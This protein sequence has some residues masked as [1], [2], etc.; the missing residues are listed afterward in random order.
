MIRRPPR[1]TLFPYTTLF[2]SL[3]HLGDPLAA[4]ELP[5]G[6]LV[7]IGGELRERRQ[8]AGLGERDGEA[9]APA[10]FGGGLGRS[11]PPRTGGGGGYWGAGAGGGKGRPP[12]RDAAR[13][14]G[15]R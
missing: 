15:W 11:P 12:G 1:S 4:L 7:Q 3:H 8:L 13:R 5:A 14:V 9:P 10:F 6:R 2:R